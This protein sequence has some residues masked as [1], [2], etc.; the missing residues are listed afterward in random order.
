MIESSYTEHEMG[1]LSLMLLAV[2]VV[3]AQAGKIVFK[4]KS[5]NMGYFYKS[6]GMLSEL[7]YLL[8][9]HTVYPRYIL[10]NLN[11]AQQIDSGSSDLSEGKQ[12]KDFM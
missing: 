10:V 1:Y 12:L 11:S 7:I 6:V 5:L 2:G 3:T 8:L 9:C 4:L